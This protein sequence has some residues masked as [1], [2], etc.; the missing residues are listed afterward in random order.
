VLYNEIEV[1]QMKETYNEQKIK[2]IEEAL[3]T[4]LE[5]FSELKENTRSEFDD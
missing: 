5:S 1:V 3:E 2:Q 4:L